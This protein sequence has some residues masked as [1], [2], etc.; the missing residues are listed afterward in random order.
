MKILHTSDWHLGKNLENVSRMDE[1]EKF[2]EDFVDIVE[3]NHIDMVIIAGDIYD[4]SN[5]P[6][7]AEE[8]FYKAIKKISKNG[9]RLVLIIAGN[10][11]NPNRLVAANPLAYEQGILLVSH[12]KTIVQTGK[13]GEYK[14][15][16]AG[17]GYIEVEVKN[18]RAVIITIP[19]PSEKRLN[20]VIY[21]NIEDEERQKAYTER[22]G[23]L[24][25]ELS[26]KYRED[27]INIAVSH[28]YVIGGEESDSERNIQLGGSLAV[29]IKDLP[30]KADYIALGHLHRPQEVKS[31]QS[32]IVYAGSPLQYSKSEIGYS[33][34]CYVLDMR[35]G[36]KPNVEKVL[37]KNYK[38]IEVWK[39]KNI[40]EAIERCRENSERDLWVYIEIK[41][42]RY[43][44]QEDIKTMK[45]LKKDILE[46]KPIIEREDGEEDEYYDVK[47]K[48]IEELFK[49]FYLKSRDVNPTEEVME[50]FLQIINEQGDEE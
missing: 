26:K 6:A 12:P 5:P 2:I 48:K 47:E 30:L 24:F 31:T 40:E 14:V 38:P 43:I 32:K 13:C 50:L 36:E 11:D 23:E 20:E 33:K 21:K 10:H 41:T 28:L 27:T 16:D 39:C 7:R 29:H 22:L 18:E 44:S 35:A 34:C 37:F 46:I 17:E 49:D 8:M 45:A 15:V 25:G 3:K 9:K 19:Y 1:Q 42:D 4:H